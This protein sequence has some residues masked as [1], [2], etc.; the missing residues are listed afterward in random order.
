MSPD[1]HYPRI[2]LLAVNYSVDEPVADISK[3]SHHVDFRK[4]MQ[5]KSEFTLLPAKFV[6]L[7]LITTTKH[8]S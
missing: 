4:Y 3:S 7:A 1:Y 6:S 5:K 8:L 2:D